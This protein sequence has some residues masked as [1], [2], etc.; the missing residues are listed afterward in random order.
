MLLKLIKSALFIFVILFSYYILSTGL[1][2]RFWADDFCHASTLSKHGFL[3][4]QKDSWLTWS[5]RYSYNYFLYFF[6]QFGDGVVKYIPITVLTLFTLSLW[7]LIHK[8][9]L[10]KSKAFSLILSPLFTILVLTNTGNI[11][12]SFYWYS[13]T[14]IYSLPFVFLNLFLSLLIWRDSK[15]LKEKTNTVL[16]MSFF[17]LL[18]AGGFN[19]S[20]TVAQLVFLSF[21]LLINSIIQWKDKKKI[22]LILITGIT[23]LLLSLTIMYFSPGTTA[24]STTVDKPESIYWVVERTSTMTQEF[25]SKL[26]ETKAFLYT[27][28]LI[29]SITYFI[30]GKL[31][32]ARTIKLN[33]NRTL[34]LLV[35]LITSAIVS[36]ASIYATSYYAMAYHPPERAMITATYI[37]V[38]SLILSGVLVNTYLIR[39]LVKTKTKYVGLA[40]FGIFITSLLML[41]RNTLRDWRFIKNDLKTYADAWDIQRESIMNQAA[42]GREIVIKYVPPVG[43]IDGFKDNK[44][45]VTGCAA[46][47]FGVKRFLVE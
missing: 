20:F 32:P 11:I 42:T 7:P 23:G 3:G 19:E 45:W 18:I 46:N 29:Y 36:T 34:I 9:L 16:F 44:G 21:L 24:R 17:L 31:N 43:H 2:V 8:L 15:L 41:S 38:T 12:Q 14:L 13:G 1:Y 6:I 10:K 4:S 47:Y 35:L 37:I 30:S 22:G 40:M 27:V 39:Q 25:F 26:F 33:L 5:G 28:V